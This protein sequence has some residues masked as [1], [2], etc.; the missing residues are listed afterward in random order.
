MVVVT[1]A[2]LV[3]VQGQSVIVRVVALVTV[4]ELFGPTG[5]TVGEGP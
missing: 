2:G 4:I 3:R 5:M 1:T